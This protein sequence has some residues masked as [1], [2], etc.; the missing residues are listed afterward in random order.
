MSKKWFFI[1]AI[2]FVV[3][4]LSI[5]DGWKEL[6][7]G[8][9]K[10]SIPNEWN[11]NKVQGEDSFIG[12]I[13]G[14]NV[15]IHFDFSN[16]GYAN[17][18]IP[19]EQEYLKKEEWNKGYFYKPGVTYTAD[20]NVKDE[21]AAQMKKL[22]TTDSTLVHVDADPS[23]QTKINTHLPTSMEKIRFPKADYIAD[24]T[25]KDSTIYVPI[26]I[27]AAIKNHNI[28]IDSSEKYIIKTI[29][30]K[31]PSQG[32]TAIYFKGRSSHLTFNMVGVNLSKQDQDLALKAFKTIVIK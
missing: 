19:T 8:S 13:N 18:L 15:S 12:E 28:Q 20:F 25:F 7:L 5:S 27:P 6:D 32:V 14:P 30:P 1:I 3:T 10:I 11:Y 9:F 23:Y 24:L 4:C 17:S 31:I 29:W 16:S 21:K 22:G 2:P 26:E